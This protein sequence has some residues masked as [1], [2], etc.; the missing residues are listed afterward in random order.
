MHLN[1]PIGSDIFDANRRHA[2]RNQKLFKSH[3]IAAFNVMG[4]IGSGKTT[5]IE[6]AIERLGDRYRIGVVAGDIVADIDASRFKSHDVPTVAMNTG[7]E[8]HLDAHLVDHAIKDLPLADLDLVVIENVGN[9]ICPTDFE[10][11]ENRR[12]VVVSV[13]EG[14]DIVAKHPMIFLSSDIVIVNKVDIAE[15]VGADPDKMVDDATTINP[16]ITALKTS[17]KA[18]E[19]IDTWIDWIEACLR[20]CRVKS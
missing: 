5:L 7:K 4:A 18:G 3:G 11:G 1:I 6:L 20:D 19:G 14:D 15:F 9:L 17:A 10:L 12:V 2:N 13:S 16:K 8:C